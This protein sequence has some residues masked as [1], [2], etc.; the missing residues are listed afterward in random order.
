MAIKEEKSLNENVTQLFEF[1]AELENLDAAKQELKD[2]VIT[3]EIKAQIQAY[4]DALIP[5]TCSNS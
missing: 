1:R 4:T 2:R 3:P 5:R